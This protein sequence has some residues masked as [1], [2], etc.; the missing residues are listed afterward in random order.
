MSSSSSDTKKG[1][2]LKSMGKKSKKK[3]KEKEV[4]QKKRIFASS[5][6]DK[7]DKKALVKPQRAAL[8]QR[9]E[10]QADHTALASLHPACSIYP[11][12][13]KRGKGKKK[14]ETFCFVLLM[15]AKVKK[16]GHVTFVPTYLV[17]TSDNIIALN[18]I[19]L[20]EAKRMSFGSL[21][22]V[23]LD[24][25]HH[26]LFLL[27]DSIND[28]KESVFIG[29]ARK[30]ALEFVLSQIE[31]GRAEATL[32]NANVA[33]LM[34][35]K[36]MTFSTAVQSQNED[37][38]FSAENM[39]RIEPLLEM[40]TVHGFTE[41]DVW[42][43]IVDLPEVVKEFQL[44][45]PPGEENTSYPIEFLLPSLPDF[46]GVYTRTFKVKA[47]M[48]IDRIVSFVCSKLGIADAHRFGLSTL[49]GQP[50]MGNDNLG[51]WG[52]G[53]IFSSWQLKIIQKDHPEYTGAFLVEFLM[54]P[55][56]ES[57]I[58]LKK[59][60]FNVDAYRPAHEI[61]AMVCDKLKLGSPHEYDLQ[62]DKGTVI[63]RNES[64]SEHGLGIRVK[65]FF[66]RLNKHKVPCGT[67]PIKDAVMVSSLVDDIVNEA[68]KIVWKG[69]KKE[70][71]NGCKGLVYE[72]I[73]R[74]CY[75]LDVA[76]TIP[77]RV[78]ALST[79]ARAD[80]YQF[81][82]IKEREERI[83]YPY[84][85]GFEH[86]SNATKNVERKCISS[87][88]STEDFP[89]SMTATEASV[90]LA[91]PAGGMPLHPMSMMLSRSPFALGP[92]K[93]DLLMAA[94]QPTSFLTELKS[95]LQDKRE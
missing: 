92:T 71:E 80:M 84:L 24:A 68:W 15:Q 51:N 50:M 93:K 2:W 63:K 79:R 47:S 81:L 37:Y 69:K 48:E 57:E 41:Q 36:C 62:T 7:K 89:Y 20:S 46:G 66:V 18:S 53:T 12:L 17:F 60:A 64:L 21:K 54:S 45:L 55:Q 82:A 34:V 91:P 94:T 74:A 39:E 10:T 77:A 3:E 26:G 59:K 40:L 72:M 27:K 85:K 86:Y 8:A 23:Q 25:T 76:R 52:L 75:A 95:N 56:V 83:R 16:K 67:D 78:A 28:K 35:R 88:P 31:K 1:G 90:P 11:A 19:N 9:T 73:T 29:I 65:G 44:S 32:H 87:S 4:P 14:K 33:P 61:I 58:K 22:E 5:K 13:Q 30:A 38:H 6:K 49:R 42:E 43:G 70:I